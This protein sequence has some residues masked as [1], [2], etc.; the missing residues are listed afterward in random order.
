MKGRSDSGQPSDPRDGRH[1]TNAVPGVTIALFPLFPMGF[2]RVFQSNQAWYAV[3]FM[4]TGRFIA[5]VGQ[6]LGGEVVVSL[7]INPLCRRVSLR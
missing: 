5:L 4:A 2:C 1:I 7:P 3:R 6:R